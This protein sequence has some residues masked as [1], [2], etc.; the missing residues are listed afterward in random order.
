[1]LLIIVIAIFTIRLI[2]IIIIS[3]IIILC[4]FIYKYDQLLSPFKRQRI[5]L[6]I[7]KIDGNY[8]LG[9]QGQIFVSSCMW[10]MIVRANV[11][12]DQHLGSGCMSGR[13]I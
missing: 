11:Q 6:R 3:I 9:C 10:P 8:S 4:Y 13:S 12:Y 7:V 2:I 5:Y 1:M